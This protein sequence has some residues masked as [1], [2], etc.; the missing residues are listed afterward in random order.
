[1]KKYYVNMNAQSNGDHEVHTED[2]SWL[3][4]SENRLYLGYFSNCAD[5]VKEARKHYSKVDGCAYCCSS[6]HA[7]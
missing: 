4:N 7:H 1:M 2:C 3:P 5:A 6:C